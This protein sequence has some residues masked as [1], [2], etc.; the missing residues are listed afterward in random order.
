MEYRY[1]D[2]SEMK[3]SGVE[4]IGNIP[5]D[6]TISRIDK[7]FNVR[8]EKVSDKVYPPLSVTKQGILPQLDNVAK[9]D[10]G[11]N[12]K[13]VCVGDFVINS[14][15]DRKGS[16]G[17]SIYNGSV[18]LICNVLT[19]K[20]LHPQYVHSL[21]RNYYFSEEFYRWGSGIVDD[22]WSTNIEKM[23]KINIPIPM[24]KEDEKIANFL[25]KKTSQF[26]SIISKKEVLIEKLEE[27]KKSLISEV[28]TGKVK[29]VKTADGYDLVKRSSDEMKDSGVEWLGEIPKN[30]EVNKFKYVA[31]NT[32]SKVKT[33]SVDNYIGLEN[34]E[35]KTG[36]LLS[37]GSSKDIESD[38]ST[39]FDCNSVLFG[40]LR[41]YLA[42]CIVTETTGICSD[43]FLVL[44][45]KKLL[46]TV[47]KYIM[48]DAY[49]IDLVNSSTY[50]AKMPR[51]NWDFISNMKI[52]VMDMEE[53]LLIKNFIDDRKTKIDT[54]IN[55]TKL[56]I[57]KLKEAK[58]SLISEAVTGKIEVLN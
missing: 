46:S 37:Y 29:V 32:N 50:G 16:C 43:E 58:Q 24:D 48:L 17:V 25:D 9:S 57:E 34:V 1:R 18:S 47:L 41:P 20:R 36:K 8:N 14:R 56:Q 40:K 22:L 11:D 33:N 52:P 55:K 6:W 10:N 45:S 21:F 12:R 23:K 30:W 38:M 2:A 7:E 19:P 49:F 53:Q 54:I 42:K 27:A 3:D 44:K 28:V 26:D 31:Y 13:K 35:S 15:A 5:K 39:Y 51:V 4:W